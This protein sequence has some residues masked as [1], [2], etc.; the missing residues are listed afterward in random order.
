MYIAVRVPSGHQM[1]TTSSERVAQHTHSRT[2]TSR[3]T[4]TLTCGCELPELVPQ[5]SVLF[6]KPLNLH[7]EVFHPLRACDAQLLDNFHKAPQTQDYDERRNLLDNT[8]SQY[9]DE[10]TGDNDCGIKDME[11]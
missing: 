8:A 4:L 10:K 7:L 6:L 9:I 11:P 5:A 3:L 2:V 1:A